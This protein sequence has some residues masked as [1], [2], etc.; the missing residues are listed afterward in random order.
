MFVTTIV[1]LGLE[2]LEESSV[3]P[4]ISLF[5]LL[6]EEVGLPL[7]VTVLK[8][9]VE[10]VEGEGFEVCIG[11]AS[12]CKEDRALARFPFATSDMVEAGSRSM[13]TG[14]MLGWVGGGPP[15]RAAGADM[16]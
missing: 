7:W 14:T 13:S 1:T 15:L 2:C 11:K 12:F 9:L 6:R 4:E 10:E 5:V 3:F 16:V 8:S